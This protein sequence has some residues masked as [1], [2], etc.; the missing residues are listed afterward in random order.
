MKRAALIL[1]SAAALAATDVGAA[2]GPVVRVDG[3]VGPFRIDVTT[4]AQ[5]RA[6]AGKPDRVVNRFFPPSKTPVGRTLYYGC[7]AGCRTAYSINAATG[8]LSDFESS[9]PRFITERGSH[10]GMP[11]GKAARLEGRK[12]V[13]GCGNGLYLHLRWD[14]HHTFVVT[15]WRGK[16]EEIIYLGS[17]SV[18]YDGLC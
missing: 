6:L 17:H 12:L 10:V 18:Y 1:A 14:Q 11:A 4:E 15:T 3:R 2:T 13:P 5:I 7:G 9:A 16:V 8:R